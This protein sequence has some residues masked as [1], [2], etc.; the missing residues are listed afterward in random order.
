MTGVERLSP[1]ARHNPTVAH[2]L[3]VL[4]ER[5]KD[6][7]NYRVFDDAGRPRGNVAVIILVDGRCYVGRTTCSLKDQYSRRTGYVLAV[8]RAIER[9]G[10]GMEYNF[11]VPPALEGVH[12]RDA[13][14]V[15]LGLPMWAAKGARGF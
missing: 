4:G 7:E 5:Y 8:K 9:A 6:H 3:G 12:L 1:Y 13:C 15:L 10:R 2:W 11:W 14:R